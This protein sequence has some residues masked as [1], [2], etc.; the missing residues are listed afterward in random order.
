M[1]LPS[2]FGVKVKLDEM[3]QFSAGQCSQQAVYKSVEN[4]E[5]PDSYEAMRTKGN[6]A[7]KRASLFEVS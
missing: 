4:G 7:A 5:T 6:D 2:G 3:T 1:L